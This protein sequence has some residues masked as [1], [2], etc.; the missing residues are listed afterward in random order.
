MAA[1]ATKEC[2]QVCANLSAMTG[3]PFFAP[4][5]QLIVD[6]YA[7]TKGIDQLANDVMAMDITDL[8]DWVTS[9]R[10]GI[11]ARVAH[12]KE[13]IEEKIEAALVSEAKKEDPLVRAE[14]L[15]IAASQLK[16]I[17][18]EDSEVRDAARMA[19]ARYAEVL[20]ARK[21]RRIEPGENAG[22]AEGA[23]AE[24]AAVAP[25]A[26]AAAGPAEGDA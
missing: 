3:F 6:W 16:G 18:L 15:C 5:M 24:G 13:K 20:Q 22:A 12:R 17:G 21:K 26:G 8:N 4:D 1:G 2:R 11:A 7:E 23:A 14:C 25:A 19:W 9:T 10:R